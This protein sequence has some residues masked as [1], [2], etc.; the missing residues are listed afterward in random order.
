MIKLGMAKKNQEPSLLKVF[1]LANKPQS[2]Y[3]C[4][5]QT[6]YYNANPDGTTTIHYRSVSFIVAAHSGI[7]AEYL[8]PTPF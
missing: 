3:I 5:E 4:P 6:R 2:I 7:I 1:R 8:R